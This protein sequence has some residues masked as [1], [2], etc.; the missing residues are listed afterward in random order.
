M[1]LRFPEPGDLFEGRY[2]IEAQAGRG[3]YARIY[4]AVQQ[5]LERDVALKILKPQPHESLDDGRRDA[6]E[7]QV[8]QRF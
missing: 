5:Q 4:R 6:F 2:L 1:P 3:G 7:S 8:V